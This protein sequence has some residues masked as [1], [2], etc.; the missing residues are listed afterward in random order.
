ME[1]EN[2]IEKYPKSISL[3][4]IEIILEQMKKKICRINIGNKKGIGFFCKIPFPDY[5]NLLPVLITNNYIIDELIL[6]NEKKIKIII[7]NEE[8]EIELENRIKY[9]NNE[10]DITI[11]EIKNKDKINNYLELDNNKR[12]YKSYK[13]ESIYILYYI[14]NKIKVSYGIIKEENKNKFINIWNIEKDSIGG[15]IINI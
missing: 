11:I 5:N 2:K 8:K 6:K 12:S 10:Y 15:I 9:I 3:E 14:R 4:G 1:Y 13:G 7:N